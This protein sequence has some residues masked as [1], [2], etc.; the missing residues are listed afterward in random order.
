MLGHGENS[1]FEALLDLQESFPNL[2]MRPLIADIRDL[3]R[4]EH[5]FETHKPQVVFHAAAHK[6]VP[7]MEAN[8]EEAI[9]NNVLGTQQ[10]VE[11][12]IANGVERFVMIS[13]DKAIHPANVMGA[14]K[15]I[16]EMIVLDAAQRTGKPFTVVRF[17]NVLG[18]RGSVVP[19]FK[20]Q[21]AR[22]GPITITHPDMKRYFMTIPEAVYLVLQAASM[23]Q[24]GE[25][26]LLN[27]GEQVR[28]LDL[29]EDLIRLSGLEPGKDIEIVFTGIRPGEKLSEELWDE[30]QVFVP[31]QHPDIV[32][33]DTNE[34][35]AGEK[36][37]NVVEEL[38]RKGQQGDT[39]GIIDTLDQLIPGSTVSGEQ[40][41][42][43]T[44]I[45]S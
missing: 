14:T 31:T 10:V 26:F 40:P 29:A 45:D 15:R 17:G 6:H 43:F 38:I 32:K 2:K 11:A 34:N 23:G 39:C 8:V 9:S 16:A 5:L 33:L 25:E 13:T 36:L 12:A 30:G 4:I 18:S 37:S 19:L 22:G 35:L 28:I 42:E 3:N 1:I 7:L 27:M 44:S 24:G 20:R 41:S 21:I